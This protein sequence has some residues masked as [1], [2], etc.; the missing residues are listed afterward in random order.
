[1]LRSFGTFIELHKND[2]NIVISTKEKSS[3][4]TP[5]RKFNLCP[6]FRGDFSFVEIKWHEILHF[7]TNLFQKKKRK[8]KKRKAPTMADAF[9]PIV[10]YFFIIFLEIIAPLILA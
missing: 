7:S 8:E 5:Q 1:M 4:V 2:H 9:L 10:F 3:Q 6:A